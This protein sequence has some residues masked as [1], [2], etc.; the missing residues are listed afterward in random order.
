MVAASMGFLLLLLSATGGPSAVGRVS[1]ASSGFTF[2][3]A[4]AFTAYTGLSVSLGELTAT[5]STFALALG[6]LGF[7]LVNESEWCSRVHEKFANVEILAGRSDVGAPPPTPVNIN[8]LINACPFT[9]NVPPIGVYGKEYYFDYP[10]DHPM[11]R[12]ILISPDLR[13]Y[14]DP[15]ARLYN[16]S[17]GTPHYNW[18]AKAIDDARALGIPWVVVGTAKNCISAGEHPC[19]ITTDLFNML[20]QKK[21]DLIIQGSTHNY[22]RSKQLAVDGPG[23]TG[24]ELASYNAAC[25]AADGAN[26]TYQKGAGSVVVISG[27]G[28]RDTLPFDLSNPYA[29]YF[30]RWMGNNSE[31]PAFGT[32]ID[33]NGVVTVNVTSAQISIRTHFNVSYVDNFTISQAPGPSSSSPPPSDVLM[34]V[35]L[36]AVGVVVVA[37]AVIVWRRNRTRQK[38]E[39]PE[40]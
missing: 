22:E 8:N 29:P 37:G 30:A 13:Y 19:E 10:L 3:F 18:T 31:N 34:Y 35:L 12:F 16:Y 26:G 9:L 17:A 20:L 27:T 15:G 40:P 23:C 5:N 11:A 33:G 1:A 6:D 36:V 24:I 4:G 21:V 25:V 14:V 28:G 2:S 7:G 39:E 38:P 32:S